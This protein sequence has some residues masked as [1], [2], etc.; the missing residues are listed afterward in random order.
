MV[1]RSVAVIGRAEAAEA[2]ANAST[3]RLAARRIFMAPPTSPTPSAPAMLRSAFA[4]QCLLGM[5]GY[6]PRA[7]GELIEP[8]YRRIRAA[9]GDAGDLARHQLLDDRRQMLVEPLLEHRLQH[10]AD[11]RLEGRCRPDPRA[12]RRQSGEALA[13]G[14]GGV[15]RHQ[16]RIPGPGRRARARPSEAGGGS[17]N[18]APGAG[19][20]AGHAAVL[21]DHPFDRR[22]NLFHRRVLL[23]V[24]H[25]PGL[26]VYWRRSV[27]ALCEA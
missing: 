17:G 21:R 12:Q 8:A 14:R 1:A 10:L 16:P 4:D 26:M 20:H 15:A 23:N 3:V 5:S 6:A 13:A 11:H 25:C 19:G 2:E 18:A 7:A 22:E 27:T 9:A 24:T